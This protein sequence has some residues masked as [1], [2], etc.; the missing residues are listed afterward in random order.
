MDAHLLTGLGSLSVVPLEIRDH[1]YRQVFSNKY[2]YRTRSGPSIGILA[3]SKVLRQEATDAFYSQSTFQ[4]EFER[5]PKSTLRCKSKDNPGMRGQELGLSQEVVKRLDHVEVLINMKHYSFELFPDEER[6]VDYFY[7]D[8]FRKLTCP[9]RTRKT[10]RIIFHEAHSQRRLKDQI[11]FCQDLRRLSAFRNVTLELEFTA[12]DFEDVGLVDRGPIQ[13]PWGAGDD[14]IGSADHKI[15]VSAMEG[16][17]E[18][19]RTYLEITL[20]ESNSYE[21]RQ[22]RCLEFH[23][24]STVTT[25]DSPMCDTSVTMIS[26]RPNQSSNERDVFTTVIPPISAASPSSPPAIFTTRQSDKHSSSQRFTKMVLSTPTPKSHNINPL[27]P[28]I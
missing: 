11:P 7:E 2:C 16:M 23:P 14:Y 15:F 3:A 4:F 5:N 27:C 10:C 28:L 19:L 9:D 21:R 13:L 25:E 17:R 20:G 8:I 24:K 6:D 12:I 18:R 1:I 26:Y 22:F